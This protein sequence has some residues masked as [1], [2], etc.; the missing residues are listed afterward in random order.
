MLPLRLP[1]VLALS[2]AAMALLAASAATAAPC[3]TLARWQELVENDWRARG[4][5]KVMVQS[6]LCIKE[7]KVPAARARV[8]VQQG[9]VDIDMWRP[10]PE[11]NEM[12]NVLAVPAG[13]PGFGVALVVRKDLP[14]EVRG[15]NDMLPY[16]LITAL[17]YKMADTI[18]YIQR[19]HLEHFST[20]EQGFSMLLMRR[21]DGVLMDRGLYRSMVRNHEIDPA[22][23]LPPLMVMPTPTHVV[24]HASR[25]EL[26]PVLDLAV[27]KALAEGAFATDDNDPPS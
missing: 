4:I 12:T 11:L 13:L 6:G 10:E 22:E 14:I 16:T 25:R 9:L 18:P 7:V 24:V 5:E 17:A 1:L 21:A 23:F 19:Y 2:L 15:L 20:M 8:M 26:I 27:R 3:Y